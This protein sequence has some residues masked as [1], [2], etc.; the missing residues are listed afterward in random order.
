M[1]SVKTDAVDEFW[2]WF[3]EVA[4]ILHREWN[5]ADLVEA[6][7]RR[8]HELN[9]DFSWEIGPH[10]L[11]DSQ[12]V[13]SPGLNR[14]LRVE[15]RRVVERAPTVAAW[16]FFAARQPKEWD[17]RFQLE[18]G[19]ETIELDASSWHFVLLKYDNGTHEVLLSARD[20]SELSPSE[21]WQAA[22]IVLESIL[23]EDVILDRLE[24]FDL[25][26]ELP[27]QLSGRER[28]IQE[29]RKAMGLSHGAD[30]AKRST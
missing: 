30:S 16:T 15:A 3:Q 14:D 29:L 13:I 22:A 8:I 6:L 25:V 4:P 21:R 24:E 9:P 20:A 28:P 23:G 11:S 5:R 1:K 17:Y 7:D 12:L 18:V 27:P 19:E 2:Q 10:G 26:G